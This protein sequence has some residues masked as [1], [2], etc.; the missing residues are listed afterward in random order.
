IE[1]VLLDVLA[2]IAFL[3]RQ[4]EQALLEDRI[5]LVPQ[6]DAQT[7]VLIAIAEPGNRVL[8]PAIGAAARMVERKVVPGVAVGGVVLANRHPGAVADVGP[9]ALPVGGAG[10]DLAEARALGRRTPRHTCA[11]CPVGAAQR[12]I[13]RSSTQVAYSTGTRSSVT[14]VAMVR[15]PICA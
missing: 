9:P 1:V 4:P 12:T 5:A 14:K 6:R 3:V 8:A 2:V 15:P 7:Q 11:A 10:R 13:F